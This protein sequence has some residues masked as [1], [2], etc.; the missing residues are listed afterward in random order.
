LAHQQC[1]YTALSLPILSSCLRFPFSRGLWPMCPQ[2]RNVTEL[3]TS[4]RS[5]H[6]CP[7][8]PF[9]GAS[10]ALLELGV[11]TNYFMSPVESCTLA[12]AGVRF[13]ITFDHFRF[14]LDAALAHRITVPLSWR[15]QEVREG[16]IQIR[17]HWRHEWVCNAHGFALSH[18]CPFLRYREGLFH[19]L[20][21]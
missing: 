10:T 20:K 13:E 14:N 9:A 17:R 2:S 4:S 16:T 8:V 7:H 1:E 19:P 21:G 3:C 18:F 12:G 15:K 6:P 11:S 5:R